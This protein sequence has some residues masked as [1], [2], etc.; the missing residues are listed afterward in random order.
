LETCNGLLL[1]ILLTEPVRGIH[2]T[3]TATKTNG[4]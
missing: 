4:L 3:A 1:A 2:V